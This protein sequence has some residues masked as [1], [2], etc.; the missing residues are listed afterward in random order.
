[1][2]QFRHPKIG[3]TCLIYSSG[4]LVCHGER[5]QLRKYCRLLQKMGY[6]IQFS[7]IK[8]ATLSAAYTL[9]STVDYNKLLDYFPDA[10]YESELF[11]GLI[12]KRKKIS[13]T[14]FHTGQVVI[15]GIKSKSDKNNIVLPLL[16][17]ME[18]CLM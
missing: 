10:S 12:Y 7:S 13:F 1:M 11:N 6:A 8:L 16:L 9:K 3:G 2:L 14:V 17:D 15:T 5:Y 18:L 4:K